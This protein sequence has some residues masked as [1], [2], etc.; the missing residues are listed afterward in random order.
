MPTQSR[1]EDE[2]IA[3]FLTAYEGGSWTDANIE[4]L[5]KFDDGAVE[6]RATRRTDGKTL[7][8]EHTIIE[9]FVREKQDFA[10][11]KLVFLRIEE[12]KSLLV[13]KRGVTVFVPVGVLRG[14][15]EKPLQEAIGKSLHSWLRE[16]RLILPD[17]RSE[18]HCTVTYPGH[19]AFN[20]KLQVR[21][22]PLRG[23]GVLHVRRQQVEN[24]LGEVIDRALRRKLPKLVATAADKRVLLLERQHMNLLPEAMLLEID[25]R[26]TAF[27]EL[28]KIDEIWIVETMFYE[29]ESHVG[30]EL[31]S[32]GSLVD[33][34]FFQGTKLLD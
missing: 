24:N 4:W 17:G 20:I 14:R 2:I 22:V 28:S 12:D 18:H 15:R 10:W 19:S 16:N 3:R 26:R 25:K 9:P 21:V 23:R 8:I 31:Y 33:S 11:F 6:A 30:F 13:D 27:N 1:R 5:D 7:A 32:N 29:I 34:Y